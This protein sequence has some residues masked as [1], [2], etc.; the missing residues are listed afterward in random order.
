M[1]R[2]FFPA[3]LGLGLGLG[4]VSSAAPALANGRYPS[5]GQ[6]ALDSANPGTI[7]VRATYGILV[8]KNAG[9]KWQYVCEGSVGYNGSEDPMMAFAGDGTLLAGLFE[10]LSVSK[11][12]GCQWDFIT[13]GLAGRYVIDLA[14]EKSDAS[15]GVLIIS[16]SSG[17]ND[18]GVASFLTQLWE[19]S[20][21]GKTWTQAGVNLPDQFLGLTVDTAPSDRNRVYAS[22]R[23]GAPNYPGALE[24]SDDRGATW[25]RLDIPGADDTHLPYIAAIDPNNPDVVYVRLDG[26]PKDQ[27]V[28]SKDGGTTWTQAYETKGNL[29]AFALSPD[30]QT[31]A[32]GGPDDGLLTA[33]VSTLSFTQVS[34][35]GLLCLTWASDGMYACADEFKDGF[36]AGVSKD[37]GKTFTAI[38]HLHDLCGPLE[39]PADTSTAKMCPTAWQT[40]LTS[41]LNTA[42]CPSDPDAGTSGSS[43]G[44]STSTHASSGAAGGKAETSGSGGSGGGS[45][46]GSSGCSTASPGAASGAFAG[47]AVLGLIA[48]AGRSRRQG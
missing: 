22:G 10:G 19:T 32:I 7:V 8:S 18:A 38:M 12:T 25:Q 9:V 35:K 11:D 13:G 44:G 5:A 15:K 40:L 43:S 47:L 6:I 39:C 2:A 46:G 16:N 20:D 4:V 31:L 24:R 45:S 27:L 42:D 17:V 23:F 33:P 3:L 37:E 29:S 26:D 28:V 21:N 48:L 41:T 36:T 14:M 30:G 1:P 34:Q